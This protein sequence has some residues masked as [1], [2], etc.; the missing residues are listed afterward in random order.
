MKFSSQVFTMDILQHIHEEHLGIERCKSRARKIL[1]WLEMNA[2]MT[3]LVNNSFTCL[4]Y[5]NDNSK[6][7]LL[8]YDVQCLP[9]HK[10]G[11]DLFIYNNQNDLLIA[12]YYSNFIEICLL[13]EIKVQRLLVT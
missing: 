4:K 2:L 8:S 1:F 9:W 10:V 11:V 3:D 7:P 13:P 12:D 5:C 6:D